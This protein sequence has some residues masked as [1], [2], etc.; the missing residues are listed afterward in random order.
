MTCKK[1]GCL[2]NTRWPNRSECWIKAQ[3]CQEHY[4]DKKRYN[5]KGS[6]FRPQVIGDTL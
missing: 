3:L 5:P 6:R 1:E 2:N 4:W